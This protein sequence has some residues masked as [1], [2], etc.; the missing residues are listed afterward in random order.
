MPYDPEL[1]STPRLDLERPAPATR[2]S[3]VHLA[4]LIAEGFPGGGVR[5]PDGSGRR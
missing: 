2:E 4:A 3:L 5:G 1:R